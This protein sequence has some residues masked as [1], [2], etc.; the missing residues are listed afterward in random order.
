MTVQTAEFDLS[1][2]ILDLDGTLVDSGALIIRIMSVAAAQSGLPVP[3][4]DAV[5]GI[6][7]L[8][9]ENAFAALF[10]EHDQGVLTNTV[11][12]YRTEALRLRAEAND[13]EALF[14]GVRDMI[15]QL[16]THGYSL[17]IATGK[18]RRGVDHFC[19][20]FEMNGWFHTVQTPDTNPSKPHPGMIESAIAETGAHAHQTVMI[21]DTTFD[22]EMAQNAGVPGIGVAW[23][24]H[25]P[26]ALERAGACHIVETVDALPEVI[27][28][29]MKEGGK[30]E[31]ECSHRRWCGRHSGS[32]SLCRF[33]DH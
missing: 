12:A 23:G 20:R 27:N 5:A 9:L 19:E 30:N 1:L 3:S 33:I 26:D 13:P 18:A 11:H 22:I 25:S 2:A 8:S 14:P 7:G 29:I 16:R 28:R 24:N 21:G 15:A 17:G 10:P 32:R 4:E 6:I 31:A